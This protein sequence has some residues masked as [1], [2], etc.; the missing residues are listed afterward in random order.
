MV[1]EVSFLS[2]S[3]VLC[4]CVQLY[5]C[6]FSE[7][8]IN[9]L[10]CVVNRGGGVRYGVVSAALTHVVVGEEWQLHDNILHRARQMGNR[11]VCT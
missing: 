1:N 8:Q 9:K 3:C 11:Y 5:L 4:V 6:G 2:P 10:M 7:R